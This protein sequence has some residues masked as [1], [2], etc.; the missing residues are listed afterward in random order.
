[1]ELKSVHPLY[2]GHGWPAHR[3]NG[4]SKHYPHHPC[5]S[6]AWAYAAAALRGVPEAHSHVSGRIESWW[7]GVR[8]LLR[9]F[10]GCWRRENPSSGFTELQALVRESTPLR[11]APGAWELLQNLGYEEAT[12]ASAYQRLVRLQAQEKREE[13]EER[14]LTRLRAQLQ[15][16]EAR[17]KQAWGRHKRIH[18][19]VRQFSHRQYLQRVSDS[20][21]VVQESSKGVARAL[22]A[23]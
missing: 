18:E 22:H 20:R 13:F 3:Y 21:G 19:M 16:Q 5:P 11:L 15:P 23:Y 12:V 9:E 10:A 1:M 17:A 2:H 6:N 8:S 7:D 4:I 14:M